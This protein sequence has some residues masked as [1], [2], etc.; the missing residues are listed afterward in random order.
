MSSQVKMFFIGEKK[1][2]LYIRF[3]N[4]IF[5][6]LQTTRTCDAGPITCWEISDIEQ[7]LKA[8]FIEQRFYFNVVQLHAFRRMTENKLLV[9]SYVFQKNIVCLLSTLSLCEGRTDVDG[10]WCTFQHSSSPCAAAVLCL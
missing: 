9:A 6:N 10:M 5:H 7:L 3:P 8:R 2:T 4:G 1:N